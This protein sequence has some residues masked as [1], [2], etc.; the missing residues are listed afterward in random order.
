MPQT[1]NSLAGA[2]LNPISGPI[3]PITNSKSANISVADN[4]F[5]IQIAKTTEYGNT[6][7]VAK[8]IEEIQEIITNYFAK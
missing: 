5:V 3:K 2:S 7:M 4:G 8:T 6:F 1:S